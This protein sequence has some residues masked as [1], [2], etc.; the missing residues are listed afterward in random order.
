MAEEEN[1][2]QEL[3]GHLDPDA[4]HLASGGLQMTEQRARRHQHEA[5]AERRLAAEAA[6]QLE[7]RKRAE[8][9]LHALVAQQAITRQ[10]AEREVEAGRRREP[11]TPPELE[12][13][14]AE[15]VPMA[16]PDGESSRTGRIG[17]DHRLG[18]RTSIWTWTLGVDQATSDVDQALASTSSDR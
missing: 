9:E 6:R 18:R 7:E 12:H 11:E 5:E 13:L 14:L 17:D 10:E 2:A 16:G 1:I 4:A 8:R 3:H 15:S